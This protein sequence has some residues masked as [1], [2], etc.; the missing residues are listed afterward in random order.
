MTA[1]NKTVPAGGDPEANDTDWLDAYEVSTRTP[2]DVRQFNEAME[3]ER[4]ARIREIIRE[5]RIARMIRRYAG[6]K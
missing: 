5:R 4:E 1:R 2:E 3:E 6:G